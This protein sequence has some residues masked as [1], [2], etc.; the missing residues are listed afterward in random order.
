[1]VTASWL[2]TMD[3][4]TPPLPDTMPNT[5]PMWLWM[6]GSFK[7]D[8]GFCR[9]PQLSPQEEQSWV[10]SLMV[11]TPLYSYFCRLQIVFGICQLQQPYLIPVQGRS[12]T[13]ESAP[14]DH[15]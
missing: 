9:S 12:S 11:R 15:F 7:K 1:M 8:W 2:V 6:L 14:A 10:H 13:S 4:P 5:L 3:L